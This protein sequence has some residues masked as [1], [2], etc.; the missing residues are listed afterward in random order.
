N[1]TKQIRD[2]EAF[3]SD[4]RWTD[5]I[6]RFGARGRN[7]SLCRSAKAPALTHRT[8]APDSKRT[9]SRASQR[10]AHG[11]REWT[12]PSPHPQGGCWS[13]ISRK[14]EHDGKRHRC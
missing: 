11:I 10:V 9:T 3:V 6:Q 5:G 1:P 13:T 7:R 4:A 12:I 8:N 2:I 14:P